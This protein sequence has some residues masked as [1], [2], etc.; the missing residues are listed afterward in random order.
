MNEQELVKCVVRLIS[1]RDFFSPA[2]WEKNAAQ[3]CTSLK[4]KRN[5]HKHRPC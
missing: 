3:V 4:R 2:T 1:G 5:N